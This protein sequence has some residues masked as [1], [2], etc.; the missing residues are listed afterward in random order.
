MT[1]KLLAAG[2]ILAIV[3]Y[4]FMLVAPVSSVPLLDAN[5]QVLVESEAEAF[6]AGTVYVDTRGA[7]SE[8][9][10]G[11]CIAES[12]YPTEADWPKVHGR[13]CD[14]IIVKGLNI[15][16][17][18]CIQIS[19]ANQYWFTM[20]GTLT[21]AWNKRFPY[22]LSELGV[23]TQGAIKGESRTGDRETNDR[24]GFDR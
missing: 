10:M 2:G 15:T 14:A 21:N 5:R 24:E 4:L 20:T 13:F 1:N 6:C 23:P 19:E 18:Q 11:E 17:D 8:A 12:E 9:A 16:K 3:G 22:P 7:G